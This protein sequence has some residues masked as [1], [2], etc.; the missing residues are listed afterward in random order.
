MNLI[1]DYSVSSSDN[2]SESSS[3][4]RV[5]ATGKIGKLAPLIVANPEVA[6]VIPKSELD[7]S[8]NKVS[9]NLSKLTI[10]H[11]VPF[12]S[13]L[14]AGKLPS[15]QVEAQVID[16]DTF[17]EQ[18]YNFKKYGVYLDPSGGGT[19]Y[20]QKN[21]HGGHYLNFSTETVGMNGLEFNLLEIF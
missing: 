20:I 5:I 17:R 9:E 1:D 6:L 7:I 14:K 15:G 4:D 2:E 21:Q 12:E 13:Q 8:L 16:E 3:K 10:Q 11:I 19:Q 18:F